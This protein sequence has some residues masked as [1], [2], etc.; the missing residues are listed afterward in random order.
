MTT[1]VAAGVQGSG[2]STLLNTL[3]GTSFPVQPEGSPG[4]RTTVGAAVQVKNI[5]SGTAVVIDLEGGEGRERNDASFEGRIARF[6]V[7][8][9]DVI[10]VSVWSHDAARGLGIGTLRSILEEASLQ[11]R[12]ITTVVVLRDLAE[13]DGE[14]DV[15]FDAVRKGVADVLS[16]EH[17]LLCYSLPHPKHRGGEFAAAAA[18]LRRRLTDRSNPKY[19]RLGKPIERMDGRDLGRWVEGLWTSFVT[20]PGG[21]METEVPLKKE[22]GSSVIQSI[23][24]EL[25]STFRGLEAKVKQAGYEGFPILEYGTDA[26]AVTEK[27][28]DLLSASSDSGADGNDDEAVDEVHVPRPFDSCLFIYLFTRLSRL[29]LPSSSVRLLH[30]CRCHMTSICSSCALISTASLRTRSEIFVVSHYRLLWPL[31]LPTYPF[32]LSAI[33]HLVLHHD[34]RSR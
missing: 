26:A 7:A 22:E 25:A 10:L 20:D 34:G 1:V 5:S 29:V 28:V 33:F 30:A 24:A 13:R 8:C 23:L 15:V 19:F 18:E 12:C 32:L 16:P 27:A 17:R 9:G 3:F 31:E 21:Q 4:T 2:K 6:A 11:D 14:E